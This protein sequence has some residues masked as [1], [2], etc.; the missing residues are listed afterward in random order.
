M[1]HR[2]RCVK[3]LDVLQGLE[4]E[5]HTAGEHGRRVARKRVAQ[6]DGHTAQ[7]L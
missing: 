3:G 7:A 6:R 2:L 1:T 5:P 4:D